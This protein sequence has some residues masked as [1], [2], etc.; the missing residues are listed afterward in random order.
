MI[1]E[2]ARVVQTGERYIWVET[3]RRTGCGACGVEACSATLLAKTFRQRRLRI[4]TDLPW[5]VGDQVIIGLEQQ[6]LLRGALTVYML[7]LA[8]MLLGALLG[9]WLAF[10][11]GIIILLGL[12]G[13]LSG[14]AGVRSWMQAPLHL[15]P[16]VLRASSA[17]ACVPAL[18]SL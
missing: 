8:M 12:A 18:K 6:A 14:F 3:E 11:E 1:E 13:L 15:Q 7:P 2:R 17:T 4:A 16:L 5:Q 10:G 9:K